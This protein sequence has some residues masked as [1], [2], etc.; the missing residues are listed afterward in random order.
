MIY[1][2]C[3]IIHIHKILIH[4]NIIIILIFYF[5]YYFMDN[6]L[7]RQ[8][9]SIVAYELAVVLRTTGSTAN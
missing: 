2:Y 5:Y 6:Q 1:I 3:I 7:S 9:Y 8:R 4:H